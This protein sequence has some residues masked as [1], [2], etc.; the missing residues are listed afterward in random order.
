ML[1]CWYDWK[2]RKA[3]KIIRREMAWWGFPI[4][5]LTDE[6]IEKAFESAGHL[7]AQT[8]Y[9]VEEVLNNFENILEG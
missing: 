1:K 9:T 3:L 5:H 6:E 2:K 4:D 8:G 7:M